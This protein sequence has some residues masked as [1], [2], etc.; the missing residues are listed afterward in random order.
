ME[1]PGQPSIA[2][3]RTPSLP[4][5]G[6]ELP[7]RRLI[8]DYAYVAYFMVLLLAPVAIPPVLAETSGLAYVDAL[9]RVLPVVALGYVGGLAALLR[10]A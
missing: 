1:S 9:L 3:N 6:V 8:V 2:M 10:P 4:S 5:T 7:D